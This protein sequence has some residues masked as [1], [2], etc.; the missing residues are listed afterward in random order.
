MVRSSVSLGIPCQLSSVR[1]LMPQ[2]SLQSAN[3]ELQLRDPQTL[4]DRRRR[5]NYK[6]DL[7]SIDE[8]GAILR[9][10]LR[11]LLRY[12]R[13]LIL[14]IIV[15]MTV[16]G[17]ALSRVQPT[18]EASSQLQ[19]DPEKAPFSNGGKLAFINNT[20][21]PEYFNT[22]LRKLT[23]RK[24][25]TEV[26][27]RLKLDQD[28]KFL[29]SGP[30]TI[31]AA[32]TDFLRSPRAA[33]SPP[34]A[35][36]GADDAA[37]PGQGVVATVN[38]RDAKSGE[39]MYEPYVQRI[40]GGLQISPVPRTR[41]VRITCQHQNP[42]YAKSIANTIVEVF[43]ET[44][45]EMRTK[46]STGQ[47]EFL[48]KQ[49]AQLQAEIRE[50]DEKLSE[51]LR[52]NKVVSF[53]P[54]DNPTIDRLTGL[55]KSL[56]D[57]ENDRIKAEA[58]YEVSKSEPI[59]SLAEVKAD[60]AVQNIE[61]KIS[62]QKQKRQEVLNVYTEIHPEAVQAT[63]A[64]KELEKELAEAKN[65]VLRQIES[66]FTAAKKR[67]DELRAKVSQ[68]Q[69]VALAQNEAGITYR[70]KQD[71][72]ETKKQLLRSIISTSKETQ[73]GSQMDMNNISIAEYA[74]TPT[75]PISPR[76][77]YTLSI[78]FVASLFGGI[79]LAF[80]R[81]YLNNRIKSV[82]DVDRFVNLPTLGLIPLISQKALARISAGG[83]AQPPALLADGEKMPAD[84]N[85]GLSAF[86]ASNSQAGEAYRQL[87]TSILLSSSEEQRN[88]IILITSSQPGE[89]KTTTSF[90]TA[91][92]IAQTGASVLIVDCDL[93]RPQLQKVLKKGQPYAGL[94][95][96][97]AGQC[98]VDEIFCESPIPN[99][100]IVPCGQLPP[101]PAELLGSQRMRALLSYAIEKY[102]FI[103]LDSPPILSFAD[104][105]ILSALADSAVLV[106]HSER[107]RRD[108][109]KR[110]CRK[111]DEANT[112]ILGVV[113]NSILLEQSSYYGYDYYGYY[114]GNNAPPVEGANALQRAMNALRDLQ[115]KDGNRPNDKA[116]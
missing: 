68:Q 62:D 77:P 19:V 97:L 4:P 52:S 82:D 14:C 6:Y 40:L 25:I 66:T 41:L 98:R 64:I 22:Q 72:I 90:N 9:Q 100:T 18:Y 46:G 85:I 103:I 99:L 70:I 10:A 88:R 115:G 61:K 17:L 104:A 81:E 3:Q 109:V 87:R 101:N 84:F 50:A 65:N 112:R 28:P 33:S 26:V 16:T 36:N 69:Q 96:Y 13:T 24:L 43:V 11:T 59:D 80:L 106:V 92:S 86:A 73:I 113:L 79:G 71:E 78:A 51:Y 44:N 91:I 89:G 45:V 39:A 55:N 12:K 7:A 114:Y 107:S 42:E 94:S 47:G 21:D 67:E 35:Q 8:E 110:A 38:G 49:V 32:L 95:R 63:Q 15:V 30:T 108:V 105:T 27:K 111:L 31:G 2:E 75:T 102:D 37:A 58:R 93:R 29:Y 76:V 56:L 20:V 23:S 74:D 116:D 83:G 1:D 48:Q 34:A 5:G 53:K 54:D 60:L 57:A